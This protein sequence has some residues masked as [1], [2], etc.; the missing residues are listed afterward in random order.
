MHFTPTYSS[1]LNQVERLF[2]FVT[3]DLLQRSHHD[4]VQ[5]LE[6][7]IR[8]WVNDWNTHPKTLHLDQERRRDPR[9]TRTATTTNLRRRTLEGNHYRHNPA[10]TAVGAAVPSLH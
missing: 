9:I 2:A 5:E 1:W 3:D 10:P 6:A 4:S 8:G 7:D